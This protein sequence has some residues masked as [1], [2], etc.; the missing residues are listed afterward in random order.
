MADPI[1]LTIDGKQVKVPA[2]TLVI[3]AAKRVG[4]EVPAFCYYEGFSLQ[5]AC[6]M[7][8]VEVEKM[9]KLQ[10][11]CTLPAAEGMVVLT[12]S[13]KVVEAR[14]G[15]LEYLLS[16]HPLDCPVCDKGGECELQ[17]MT[18]RY[19]AGES[20]FV[21]I[22]H[23]VDEKQWSPAV[24]YDAARCI[25]CYRCIRVCDEG[26]G[27]GALGLT[28]RGV[29]AEITPSHG[30]HLEC[31]ECGWCIDVCPV[32]ALTS[33]T[34]R[35]KSR[36]WE[37]NYAGTICTHCSDGC[38]TTLSVRNGEVIRANNRDRSGVNG[39][40]LCVKGRFG[41][42]F[43][44][45]EERLQ[46]PLLRK[47]GKLEP[48]S[49]SEAL[50][51]VAARFGEVKA[52]NGKFGIIGSTHTSNEENYYLQKFA[53]QGLGTANI[54]HH[55]SGDVPAL[56]D[57]LSGKTGKLAT[58]ADL[59]NAK[60]ALVIGSDLAQQHPFLAF[61]L[62]ANFRHHQAAVYTVTSG[63]VREEQ[64]AAKSLH[65]EAGQE[66]G[67]VQSLAE[68]LKKHSD[69]VILFSDAVRGPAVRQLIEFGESLGI[70][71]K[72]VCLVDYANSRGAMDMGLLPD[73]GPGYHAAPAS[74]LSRDEMLAAA[75]LDVLWVVGSNP[76]KTTAPAGTG[77][78]TVVQDLFLTE[79]AQRADVVL[80]AASAYEK[81]GTV[82]NVCGEVQR[83]KQ[84]PKVMGTKSD[85][86]IF[87]LLAK[88]LGL[89]LGIW[90]AD[91][92]FEEIRRTVPGYNVPL[93]VIATGGAAQTAP[94]NG[95]VPQSGKP[96][97]IRSAGDT[98]FT[99]GTLGR[100]SKMLNRVMEAPGQLYKP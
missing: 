37:M 90:T 77:T 33:G 40:F 85:L 26:L 56:L 34:Y 29:A 73:L 46:T 23:H 32:G 53:R 65:C 94:V 36:P 82:T 60:A 27:V 12:E 48:V 19:G 55:R 15:M 18:F 95:G 57:A 21:E 87:G 6:R 59:Y 78:F 51:A 35:Y 76:F 28:Y 20:R 45:N 13:P 88:E 7:C 86:E 58:S 17:D 81:N 96:E 43:V 8:L 24:Y 68:E 39:E 52:R 16:N 92:V 44:H 98:L 69:L 74:G 38:K 1:T 14:K 47:D 11:S 75:D 71:V 83:L 67:V 99:S 84:G 72:Y 30:D 79:T 66:L 41:F 31:D 91:K 25:L 50:A 54:D 5:A 4:I 49:W 61:Q 70:P 63:P 9:P 42:D 100:Y 97:Y 89:N 22:K 3:E 64:Y 93:P 62:R 2:G 10:P 80:P